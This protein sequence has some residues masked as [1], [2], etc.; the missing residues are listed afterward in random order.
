MKSHKE[1]A[2]NFETFGVKLRDESE[3]EVKCS[4]SKTATSPGSL[5]KA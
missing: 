3:S 2:L 5:V 1:S 4:L